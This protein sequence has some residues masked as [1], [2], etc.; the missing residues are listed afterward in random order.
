[1]ETRLMFVYAS[2]VI[3]AACLVTTYVLIGQ[4]VGGKDNNNELSKQL[5]TI[6]IITGV[7]TLIWTVMTYFYFMANTEHTLPYLI[8]SNGLIMFISLM[9]LGAS[10]LQSFTI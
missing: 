4:K 6:F 8:L 1:M 7:C 5:T 3:L 9:S 2:M 10:T